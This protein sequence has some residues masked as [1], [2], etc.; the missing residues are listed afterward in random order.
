MLFLKLMDR[1]KQYSYL[2]A[3]KSLL[4]LFLILLPFPLISSTQDQNQKDFPFPVSHFK[5]KNGFQVILSED[6]SLPLVS[7]VI[8]YNVGSINELQGKAGLAYLLENLMFQGSSN[9]GRMQHISYINRIGGEWNAATTEDKTVYYQTVPS[10]Q[11]ALVFWLE[12]DRMKN[13]EITESNVHRTK[14]SIIEEVQL[15][16]AA[17]PHLE[18]FFAFDRLIFPDFAHSHPVIGNEEEING[19][20]VEDVKNFYSTFYVPN[21]AVLCVVGNVNGERAEE[22]IRKYFETIPEGK[23]A[24]S[25]PVQKSFDKKSASE[26]LKDTLASIP[27]FHL[28]YRIAPPYSRDY[29]TLK[30]LGYVLWRGKSSRLYKRLYKRERLVYDFSAGIEKRKDLAIFKLFALCNNEIMVDISLRAVLSEINKLKSTLVSEK[31]LTK[32]KNMFKMDYI[33]QFETSL[34][35]ALFLSDTFLSH[36]TLDVLPLELNKYL[37]VEARDIIGVVNRYFNSDNRILLT[38]KIK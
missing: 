37:N 20:T 33:R 35:K 29:Y 2:V 7:V 18:S 26:T 21:N 1:L 36:G 9:V 23:V 30:I 14:N 17:D 15:R 25:V 19:I 10:N 3:V 4:I 16:R 22:L 24:S 13:L 31:E 6:N 32:S 12:S 34:E 28:G 5:L 8:A 27:G 38:I 11:L